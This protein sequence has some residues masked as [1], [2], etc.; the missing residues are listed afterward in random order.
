LQADMNRKVH[1]GF[2]FSCL[3]FQTLTRGARSARSQ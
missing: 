2:S 3:I 1:L